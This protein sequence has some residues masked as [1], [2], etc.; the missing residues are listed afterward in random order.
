METTKEKENILDF[1]YTFP[2]IV[3]RKGW[4]SRY[5]RESDTFSLVSPNLS[6]SARK[7]YI[8]DEFAFYF[9][10]K[11]EIEGIF[12]EYFRTNFLSHHKKVR[13]LLRSIYDT[14]SAGSDLIKIDKK[15][16]R[17]FA[18][19]LQSVMKNSILAHVE[20]RAA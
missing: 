13:D 12:V 1:M 10:K 4:I 11:R 19:E 17:K 5:D 16:I 6:D 14:G 9:N 2:E 8:D 3:Q 20:F 7:E 15:H 18:P